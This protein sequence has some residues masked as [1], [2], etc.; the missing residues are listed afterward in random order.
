MP[1]LRTLLPAEAGTGCTTPKRSVERQKRKVIRVA[2]ESCRKLKSRVSFPRLAESLAYPGDFS[3]QCDGSE[4]SCGICVKRG[5]QCVY[6]DRSEKQDQNLTALKSRYKA[7]DLEASILRQ[8]LVELATRPLSEA[9]EI[10]RRIRLN[11]SPQAL[12]EFIKDADVLIQPMMQAVVESQSS[13]FV[14]GILQSAS[15]RYT[16]ECSPWPPIV[17]SKTKP[18]AHSTSKRLAPS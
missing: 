6:H 17:T 5:Q 2:C 9:T 8:L 14:C 11:E 16:S 13:P 15:I 4:P 12:L 3:E 1:P 10:F 7:I 18:C